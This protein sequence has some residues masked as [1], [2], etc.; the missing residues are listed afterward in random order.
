M[1]NTPLRPTRSALARVAARLCL[2][3]AILVGSVR[4]QWSSMSLHPPSAQLSGA[5]ASTPGQQVGRV[6]P[7]GVSFVNHAALWSGTA[8]SWVDLHPPGATYS[9]AYGVSSVQQVGEVSFVPGL[10]PST[11]VHAAT[12]SGSSATFVDLHPS[13]A[14]ASSLRATSGSQQVGYATFPPSTWLGHAGLW[15]GTA[16]SFIDLHPP[17][18]VSSSALDTNGT[19]QVGVTGD[20]S[21]VSHASLWTGS[22]ASW[23]DLNPLLATGSCAYSLGGVQQAGWAAISGNYHAALWSGSAASF[24]DLNPAGATASSLSDTTGT[25]Q[26][27][28]VS[29]GT[30]LHAGLWKG[31]AATFVDLHPLLGVSLVS[32]FATSVTDTGGSLEITVVGDPTGTGYTRAFV[33]TLPAFALMASTTGNG[34]GDLTLGIVGIRPTAT[35]ALLL[36]SS[37]PAPGGPGTGAFF[38]LFF[39]DPVLFAILATPSAAF[40]PVHFPVT[41]NPYAQGP[42]VFGPGSLSAL[43]GQIWDLTAICYSAVDGISGQTS[44]V[45][46]NW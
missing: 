34:V 4:G 10:F 20:A 30:T 36:V 39:P 42:L 7:A 6:V 16:S 43:S 38:G 37:T 29:F 28:R 5:V 18:S 40:S 13:M 21:G 41:A 9:Q 22:A 35:D 24:I 15:T 3:F 17:G 44:V 8:A 27:G 12:W 31:S 46:V 11:G 23:V 33:L 1:T 2:S 14:A 25:W 45:R 32:S 19:H 26:V